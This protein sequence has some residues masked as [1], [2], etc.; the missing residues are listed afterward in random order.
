MIFTQFAPDDIVS[1]RINQV[2]SGMF[3]TGSLTVAQSTF[4][5]ASIQANILTGSNPYDVKNGQY[6]LDIYS[7][8]DQYFS[9]AYG[10]Y[11]NSG[12]SY[13]DWTGQSVA[14]VLTNETKII[15]TQYK[16]TLLQPGDNYFSFASSSINTSVDSTAIFVINYVADKFQD[17]IDPG[18]IQLNFSGANGQYSYI[19]DSQVINKQQNVYN[20]IS[21]SIINGVPVPYT[22]GGTV[23]SV[24]SGVGLFYPTNGVVVLNAV[25]LDK[26]V[27][28]TGA[29]PQ[30]TETGRPSNATSTQFKNYWRDWLRKFYN[31]LQL[32]NKNMAVRKSEF[33]PSTNY[34]IRVKN[35]EF[36]YSNNPTFVSNGTDGKTQGTIIY[37]QLISNPRTY[38][39]T[40]GLY[41]SNNELL[42][43]GKLSKPT[44]KSFDNEL[45]IKCRIDF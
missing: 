22:K 41:D 40:V 2:S 30:I 25:A 38:I 9:I 10:D 36:N 15:Y 29:S 6:Y 16:N 4:A 26:I 43:V 17:Q 19:D 35:K 45:L 7:G 28:I 44:Q 34:F 12:S 32:S 20:L 18:Q 8:A 14:Q 31:S 3:G 1:G 24:Y 13:F 37:P 27:G 21:G 42:A 23:T 5:T 11:V 39:T 33:V